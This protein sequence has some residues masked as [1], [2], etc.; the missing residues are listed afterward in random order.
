[1]IRKAGNILITLILLVSTIGIII[2]FH[3]SGNELFSIGIYQEAESCCQTECGGCS[4][5]VE[6]YKLEVDYLITSIKTDYIPVIS[7]VERIICST[8]LIN[9]NFLF[10]LNS[11]PEF[12]PGLPDNP[13]ADIQVFLL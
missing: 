4:E 10:T 12:P 6:I 7:E 9:N 5:Q 8:Q 11:I 1:M 13:I 3:Y 2:H